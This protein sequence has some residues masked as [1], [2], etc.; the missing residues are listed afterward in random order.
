[1]TRTNN[2][3]R[4]KKLL[5]YSLFVNIVLLVAFHCD[6]LNDKHPE[7]WRFE[8]RFLDAPHSS[9]AKSSTCQ[10]IMKMQEEG[11]SEPVSPEGNPYTLDGEIDDEGYLLAIFYTS[12]QPDNTDPPDFSVKCF[13]RSKT[14]TI[15]DT[16]LTR[17]ECNF[18]D[19][20][21]D[22]EENHIEYRNVSKKTFYLNI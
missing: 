7:V 10:W 19:Q 8:W 6:W 21:S 18:K 11:I 12:A 4:M 9:S 1:M 14:L 15:F 16:T 2:F 5:L 22:I 3:Y 17:N 20:E 13:I